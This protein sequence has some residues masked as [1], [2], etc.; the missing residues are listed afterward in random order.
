MA[1][2]RLCLVPDLDPCCTFEIFRLAQQITP[3]I[4]FFLPRNAD[5]DQ[6]TSLA[7]SGGKVEIEQ[8]FLNIKLKTITAYFG[9]LIED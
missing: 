5:V 2:V 9:E 8:N 1:R 7:G 3:N 6:L 4:A